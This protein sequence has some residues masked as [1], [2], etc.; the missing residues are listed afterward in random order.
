[1]PEN[2]HIP[3]GVPKPPLTEAYSED[4]NQAIKLL[5]EAVRTLHYLRARS[6]INIPR[7]SISHSLF[8][9]KAPPI[10]KLK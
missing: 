8:S 5:S 6:N 10:L 9:A 2:I 1:V 7:Y 4:L 3:Q